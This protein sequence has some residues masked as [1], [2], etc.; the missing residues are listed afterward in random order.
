MHRHALVESYAF[1]VMLSRPCLQPAVYVP[2]LAVFG[3]LC[4]LGY[5]ALFWS[6]CKTFV[7]PQY[8][9]TEQDNHCCVAVWLWICTS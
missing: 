3:L 4:L 9:C 2:F 5:A 1:L 6:W 8:G 7:L